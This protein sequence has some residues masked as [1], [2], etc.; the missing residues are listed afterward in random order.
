MCNRALERLHQIAPCLSERERL[1]CRVSN[2]VDAIIHSL[3]LIEKVRL[4]HEI[5]VGER[6]GKLLQLV[7]QHGEVPIGQVR[8]EYLLSGIARILRH[9]GD[10]AL[11]CVPKGAVKRI[12]F[13]FEVAP[14]PGVRK[15]FV[16]CFGP[17]PV[18]TAERTDRRIRIEMDLQIQQL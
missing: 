12:R 6:G 14:L 8:A 7:L 16:Q 9:V 3:E 17:E 2:I 15:Q 5:G 18:H 10:K 4:R 1:S 11:Q 13:R